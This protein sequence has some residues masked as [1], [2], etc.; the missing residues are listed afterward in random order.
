MLFLS[1]FQWNL[2]IHSLLLNPVFIS[3]WLLLLF[4]QF[5][6]IFHFLVYILFLLLLLSFW[7][8]LLNSFF[9]HFIR[10][11]L[12]ILIR[13]HFPFVCFVGYSCIFIYVIASIFSL[14]FFF[15]CEYSFFFP[16]W[17]F[18]FDQSIEIRCSQ[19]KTFLPFVY[20]F[21]MVFFSLSL[22]SKLVFFV[23]S[24]FFL[25][26]YIIIIMMMKEHRNSF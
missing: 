3:W 6:C 7:F 19:V 8:G 21:F 18:L 11:C 5:V 12:S 13:F 15:G 20:T 1:I 10:I 4:A 2:F 23:S 9:S 14:V 25:W 16:F 24:Y 22:P 17:R 26:W